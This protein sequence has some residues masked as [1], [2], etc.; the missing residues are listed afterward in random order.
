MTSEL[1]GWHT[2]IC[3]IPLVRKI[4]KICTIVFANLATG[5]KIQNYQRRMKRT[6][7]NFKLQDEIESERKL[8]MS[9]KHVKHSNGIESFSL[10]W[11]RK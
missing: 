9:R 6:S 1:Q 2:T 8:Q 3:A 7:L 10:V 11:L 5:N 4:M